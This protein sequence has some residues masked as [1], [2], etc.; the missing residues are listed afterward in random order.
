MLTKGEKVLVTP[1]LLEHFIDIKKAL[2][3]CFELA[4]KQPLPNKQ[5]ALM[6]D[7]SFSAAECAILFE[8]DP[9]EKDTSTRKAF[10]PVANGTKS[11]SPIQSKMS[12]YAKEF[13]ATFFAF[14]QIGQIF[15]GP[16][17]R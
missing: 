11:F 17:N 3:R 16:R 8:G 13:L 2:D 10:A 14:K 9:L 6:T 1:H 5:I 12:V 4:L 15:W 7:A